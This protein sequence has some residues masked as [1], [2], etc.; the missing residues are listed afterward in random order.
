MSRLREQIRLAAQTRLPV[1]LV[2][3]SG[4]GKQWV[5]QSIHELSRRREQPYACLDCARLP[6]N[7][8]ADLLFGVR[9]SFAAVYLRD[10]D[11]LPR[12]LQ[13]RL[14]QRLSAAD[15]SVP[16]ICAGLE[17]DPEKL[18]A[19]GTLLHELY[20]GL[21]ALMLQVP[22][23]KERMDDFAGWLERL[24]P[25]AGRATDRVMRGLSSE[26]TQYL[27]SHA[28]P[29]N[30]RELYDVLVGACLRARGDLIEAGDLPFYLRH[31]PLPAEKPLALDVILEE[32][33]RRLIVQA[34]RL[35]KNNKSRAAELLTIWRAR[36]LRRMEHL[37]IQDQ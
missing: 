10:L 23:L 15:E 20:C 8:L 16:R 36:L 31:A 3:P 4:T 30:L 35:A 17:R 13:E 14:C 2:G 9:P 33:E 26:A 28:W 19:A 7:L 32:V 29:G 37:G 12:D 24:L 6:P 18:V 21:S 1:L 34:L 27:R 25:R 11:A 5:A 22:A